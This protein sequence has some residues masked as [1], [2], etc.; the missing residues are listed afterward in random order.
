MRH[1][2]ALYCQSCSSAEDRLVLLHSALLCA[3]VPPS[4]TGHITSPSSLA[5]ARV[6]T[7]WAI[8]SWLNGE[9]VQSKAPSTLTCLESSL[10]DIWS[11]SFA[12]GYF[13]EILSLHV[14]YQQ[15]LPFTSQDRT[16]ASLSRCA[17]A[18]R[19]AHLGSQA[20][21]LALPSAYNRYPLGSE[22]SSMC[23]QTSAHWIILI[24]L[25]C[26]LSLEHSCFPFSGSSVQHLSPQTAVHSV[27]KCSVDI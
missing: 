23:S 4:L 9:E 12:S 5:H 20:F 2:K 26:T 22:H 11:V 10:C 21:L 1:R 16:L 27:L 7:K 24:S 17:L 19:V 6:L 18:N 14:L 13:C 8:S 3:A 25:S 15:R